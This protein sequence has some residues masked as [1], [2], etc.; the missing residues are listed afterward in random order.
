[1][2]ELRH[3]VTPPGKGQIWA[4]LVHLFA[5]EA[6]E[7][8]AASSIVCCTTDMIVSRA[9]THEA[10]DFTFVI[11]DEAGQASNAQLA[12][13][14]IVPGVSSGLLV[15][16]E[17][18]LGLFG[19]HRIRVAS[20]FSELV[21]RARNEGIG[22]LVCVSNVY[23]CHPFIVNVFN[24]LFYG[25]K[26]TCGV[27]DEDQPLDPGMSRLFD[28]KKPVTWL[29]IDAPEARVGSS[30]QSLG[31]VAVIEQ[32]LFEMQQSE[33]DLTTVCVL[34]PYARQVDLL[35]ISTC[36]LYP[37]TSVQTIDS[38]QGSTF[39]YTILSLVRCKEKCDIGFVGDSRRLNV[40]LSRARRGALIV[41]SHR[42]ALGVG[43]CDGSNLA[44]HMLPR[45]CSYAGVVKPHLQA[46]L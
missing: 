19:C 25:G 22:R 3:G 7:K 39:E 8:V 9:I 23:R 33:I 17:M 13:I 11:G 26:L 21:L 45:M 43:R 31:E 38:S 46:M 12:A 44:L 40:M 16:D 15:G 41:G 4:G 2:E 14:A 27:A 42:T 35:D 24:T 36:A 32:V 18:Q 6:A 30:L 37:R 29:D 1:L 34:A 20:P 5:R 28:A 10:G